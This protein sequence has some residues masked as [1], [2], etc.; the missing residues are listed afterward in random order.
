MKK[1]ILVTS[2][3]SL[4]FGIL[5]SCSKAAAVVG[6]NCDANAQKVTDAGNA[7]F[8][9]PTNKTKCQAY[10]SAINDMY[11]A[12]PTYYPAATKKALDD[13]LANACK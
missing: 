1:I 6:A 10:V 8:A 11:K 5:M 7:F 12:C 2:I 4:S 9:D 13:A 3:L